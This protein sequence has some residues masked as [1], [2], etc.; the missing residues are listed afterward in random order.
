MLTKHTGKLALGLVVIA[1]ST[2]SPRE[3]R[4]PNRD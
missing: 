3:P 4:L 1:I 2:S